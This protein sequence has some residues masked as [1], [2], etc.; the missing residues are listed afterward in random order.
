MWTIDRDAAP[1]CWRMDL[2]ESRVSLAFTTRRGGVSLPPYDMLN[3]GRSTEDRVDFIE[4]NRRRVIA[5]LGFDPAAVATAG[6]VHGTAVARVSG[7]GLYSGVDTLVTTLPE[8]PLAVTGADCLPA[9]FVAPGAVGAAHC[10]WR[11]SADG[12]VRAALDAVCAA[13]AVPPSRVSVHLGPS[14]RS[15]CYE[16]GPEVAERFPAPALTRVDGAWRLDLVAAARIALA[17]AGVPSE[18]IH[19]VP[20]CTACEPYWYYSHRRDGPRT[21]RHWG[22]IGMHSREA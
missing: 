10:G 7:P 22:L 17:G 3:L 21:G 19:E 20:A 8:V 18:S 11:G 6:Q 2:A 5:S 14:I 16:V 12:M 1:P 4:E 13:A 9:L 15:C